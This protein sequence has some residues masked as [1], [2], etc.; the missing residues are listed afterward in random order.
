MIT[1]DRDIE[2]QRDVLDELKSDLAAGDSEIW[3]SV[4]SGVVTLTGSVYSYC[5]RAA[6]QDAATSVAGVHSVVN[7]IV[8]QSDATRLSDAD[9][10]EQA[11]WALR[12]NVL[13]P[14]DD[15]TPSVSDGV[16]TL[17]GVVRLTSERDDAERAV[18]QLAGVRE[19]R[20]LIVVEDNPARR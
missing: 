13:V 2:L 15:I 1:V 12:W 18:S 17:T 7:D 16:I 20:N 14:D 5:K 19:V 11:H 6:V 4:K 8:V 3:V 9:I 10:T